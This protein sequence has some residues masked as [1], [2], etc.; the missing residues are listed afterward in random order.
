MSFMQDLHS[1]TYYSF[2]G[3]DSPYDIIETARNGGITFF[4]ICDH[5]YGIAGQRKGMPLNPDV[6]IR[7]N[8]FARKI[9]AYCDHMT[10]IKEKYADRIRIAVGIEIPTINEE[11]LYVPKGLDLS[12]FDYCLIEHLDDPCTHVTDITRFFEYAEQYGCKNIGIAHTDIPSLL[13]EQDVDEL[14]FFSEMARRNIFWEMNVNFD[15][16]LGYHEHEYVKRTLE[17]P[18]LTEI[19]KKSG[20]KLSVGFDGHRVEDYL[21]KRIINTNKKIT[22]LGLPLVDFG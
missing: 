5:A 18:V 19:I 16:I 1:H 21:P 7:N 4:G 8:D 20:V 13:Q 2:C 11:Y 17:N 22:K 10:L 12:R 3:K 9:N 14:S 15:S 6:N